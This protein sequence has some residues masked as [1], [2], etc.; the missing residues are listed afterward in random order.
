MAAAAP[1]SAFDTAFEI[2]TSRLRFGP[3]TTG[4]VGAEL[5]LLGVQRALVFVDQSLRATP[6]FDRLRQSLVDERV[7]FDVFDAIRI[8]P[9]YESFAAAIEVAGRG[10]YQ[11]FV[12]IGGGSTIDTAKAANLFATYPAP[13]LKYVNAPVGEG[14]PVPGPLKPLIAIPT[15]SGT[16]SETTG[17]A[18]CDLTER[19]LKTGIA[20][21][22]LKPTLGILDP[23]NILTLPATVAASTGLDVLCHAVESYTALPYNRRPAVAR[24][25]QRPNYQGTN[26]ISD[27]WVE[28][29][30]QMVT[31]FLPRLVA[32]R[33]DQAARENMLLA[34]AYAGIGFGNAGVHLCH[35]MSY[36]IA[37]LVRDYLPR[38]YQ[39]D[40][41]MVPHGVSVILTAP[42]VFEFLAPRDTARHAQV[43][44]WIGY[45]GPDVHDR[46]LGQALRD[47][48]IALIKRYDLPNGLAALGYSQSDLSRLAEG[49]LLQQRLL[50]LA[51][52]A[53]GEQEL[54]RLL[55]RSLQLW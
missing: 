55:E 46:D 11:G 24:P 40:H 14:Q 26:P 36:P 27:V 25:D 38:D 32:D 47:E 17:V 54:C 45:R 31:E 20:H 18:I 10:A 43:L 37:S 2:A 33:G 22:F 15:T 3:G 19:Q 52:C 13:F 53:V 6:Q 21:R 12:A 35:A 29:S 1:E 9:S 7:A 42:A 50:K 51:P 8:E 30:I 41:P 44:R 5:K 34:A 49:A 28:K 4:E 39:V 48:L 16:G 23:D